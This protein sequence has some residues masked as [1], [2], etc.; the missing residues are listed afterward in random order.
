MTIKSAIKKEGIKVISSLDS[1]TI[2]SIASKIIEVLQSVFPEK[3]LNMPQLFSNL[4]KLNMYIA[5]LP[6]GCSAKYFY[7]NKSIYFSPDTS[8][9]EITDLVVHECIHYLQ[10]RTN[11]GGKVIRLGFCDFTS[12]TLPGTGLNEASVQLLASK[13]VN[14]K[15][16][17]VTYFDLDFD[18]ISPDYYPLECALVN[19]MAYL[20][21]DDVLFD[22]TL[23]S[24]DNFKNQFISLT[25][26]ETFENVQRNIDFL[27]EMQENIIKLNSYNEAHFNLVNKVQK[28][29]DKIEDLKSQIRRVFLNTQDIILT[30]YFD[31][32]INLLYTKEAIEKYRNKLYNFR[33]LIATS[34]GYIYFNKYYIEKMSELENRT[35][36]LSAPVENAPIVYK[37]SFIEFIINKLRYL[38]KLTPKYAYVSYYEHYEQEAFYD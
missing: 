24:N 11:K 23:N 1:S 26:K 21:G 36:N 29:Y 33:N 32:T 3:T 16:E 20:V 25:S 19:Q 31:N 9:E 34:D 35:E 17:T 7:K 6:T 15:S 8:F 28:N 12:S 2:S 18:T 4:L 37:E 30:A 27:V 22:S 14:K 5:E 38:L 13:C 10:E